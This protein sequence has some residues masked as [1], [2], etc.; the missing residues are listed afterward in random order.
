M[1]FFKSIK[2]YDGSSFQKGDFAMVSKKDYDYNNTLVLAG[3]AYVKNNGR[4]EHTGI[5]YST[6]PG[7][8]GLKQASPFSLILEPKGWCWDDRVWSF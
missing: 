1:E 7:I 8:R 4:G 5:D 6:I 2:V 3:G